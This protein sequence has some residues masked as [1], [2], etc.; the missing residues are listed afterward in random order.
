MFYY[1]C[2]LIPALLAWLWNLTC[3]NLQQDLWFFHR[4]G[5]LKLAQ[6]DQVSWVTIGTTRRSQE[7]WSWLPSRA[8]WSC[9]RRSGH[10]SAAGTILE[11]LN[12]FNWT[13]KITAFSRGIQEIQELKSTY[14]RM[15]KTPWLCC[16]WESWVETHRW[17]RIQQRHEFEEHQMSGRSMMVPTIPKIVIGKL[18]MHNFFGCCTACYGSE[19]DIYIYI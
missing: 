6:N 16:H 9:Q 10:L 13:K 4:F 19:N 15:V 3:F 11:M 2:P 1:F 5:T 14:S 12:M 17:F 7:T 18:I 8:V